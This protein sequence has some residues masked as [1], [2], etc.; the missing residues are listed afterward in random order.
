MRH[1]SSH[2]TVASGAASCAALCGRY[3]LASLKS[4]PD[5]RGGSTVAFQRVKEAYDT[6]SDPKRRQA[7]VRRSLGLPPH[8]ASG[9][10]TERRRSAPN[11]GPRGVVSLARP[12]WAFGCCPRYDEGADCKKKKNDGSDSDDEEEEEQSLREEIERKYFPERSVLQDI[13][14]LGKV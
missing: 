9:A 4:H 2:Y 12:R 13:G 3:R 7:Y 14:A 11:G 5:R 1:R 8:R 6:L 10:A